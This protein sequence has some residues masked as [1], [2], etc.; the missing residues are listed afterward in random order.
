MH[1]R[2]LRRVLSRTFRFPLNTAET[3]ERDTPLNR[4]IS[5][6]VTVRLR[7]REPSVVNGYTPYRASFGLIMA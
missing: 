2:T 7:A 6:V 5:L 4:A 1:S 3:V